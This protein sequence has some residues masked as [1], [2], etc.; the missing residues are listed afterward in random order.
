MTLTPYR[1]IHLACQMQPLYLGKSK[2]SFFTIIIYILQ[3]I[4]F[5]LK[6]TNCNPV[7][8]HFCFPKPNFT[9]FHCCL[10]L[11]LYLGK[12][13][14][15]FFS[16]IIYILQIIYFT[17]K[18]TNCNSVQCHF[19]F[20]KPNFTHFY[21]CLILTLYLGKSKKSF[22]T[23]IIYILQIIYFTSKKTNCNPVQC[24]FCTAFLHFA[25]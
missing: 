25:Q 7:Q 18:K 12:C 2:K 15:S 9:H 20:P 16:I 8:C 3:I 13:K 22:F 19:C 14:K 17:S 6:K 10:S 21:C 4:Y 11:P 1:F 23:I 5:T 24:H